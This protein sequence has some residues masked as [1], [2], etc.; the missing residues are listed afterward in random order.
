MTASNDKHPLRIPRD[1]AAALA[2]HADLTLARA[3]LLGVLKS[4]RWAPIAR[5]PVNYGD[6]RDMMNDPIRDNWIPMSG[7]TGLQLWNLIYGRK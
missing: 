5:S 3:R 1:P 7:P 6:Y 4:K 2:Q